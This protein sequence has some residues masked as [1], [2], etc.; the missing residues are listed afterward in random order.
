[1][2]QGIYRVEYNRLLT[3]DVWEMGLSGDTSAIT[4]P[5][6]F[7]NIKLDSFFLRRPISVCDWDG[8]GITIIYRA[9][10]KGTAALSDAEPGQDLDV[11]CGLGN[12]FDVSKCGQRTLVI[13][14]GVGTPPMY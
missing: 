8:E 14:G 3:K 2:T 12:G 9:A 7:I 5:G 1:M 11:L 6:Q 10:G 13:G 4:A